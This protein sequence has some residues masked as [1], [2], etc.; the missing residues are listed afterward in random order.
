LEL[1]AADPRDA[2][3]IGHD[4]ERI[5]AESVDPSGGSGR[6]GIWLSIGAD[7]RDPRNP[8]GV[9]SSDRDFPYANFAFVF[10]PATL[11]A[12]AAQAAEQP[13]PA[14]YVPPRFAP[15]W[16]EMFEVARTLHGHVFAFPRVVEISAARG[17]A[18]LSAAVWDVAVEADYGDYRTVVATT[19]G[20][21][22]VTPA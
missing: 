16:G 6:T 8:Q 1:M 2:R 13:L 14:Q 12:T 19:N 15:P 4:V 17:G 21:G 18:T 22:E 10:D 20:R 3:G 7:Y 5:A 9:S 11:G